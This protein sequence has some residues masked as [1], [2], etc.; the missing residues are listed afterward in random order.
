MYTVI[1][2][3]KTLEN[4]WQFLSGIQINVSLNRYS[5]R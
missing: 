4:G 5:M 3:G 2:M 1:A